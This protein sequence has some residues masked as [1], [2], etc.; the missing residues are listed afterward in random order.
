MSDREKKYRDTKEF[1]EGGIVERP[2]PPIDKPDPTDPVKVRGER[3]EKG[4][5]AGL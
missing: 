3:E 1:A 5:D 2:E 4:S